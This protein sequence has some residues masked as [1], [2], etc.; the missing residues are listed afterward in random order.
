MMRGVGLSLPNR[1]VLFGATTV[2]EMLELTERADASGFF[3][4]VWVGDGLVAK[5]RLEAVTSLAAIAARTKTVQLGVCCLATFALRQPVLFALQWA[6]LDFLSGGRTLLAVCLGAPTARSGGDFLGELQAMGI[7]RRERVAR[8]EENIEILRK[9]WAG[10]AAHEGRF[11]S[12]PEIDLLP[13]PVQDPCPIWIASNPS[14]EV[15]SP[16]RYQNAIDRV[17]RLADGWQSTVVAPDDFGKRWRE[18][19]ASAQRFGRDPS[20]MTS[21]VHLMINVAD[22]VEQGR[23]EGKRFLDKYYSMDV[24]DATMDKWGAYGPPEVVLERINEYMDEGLDIPIVRFASYDQT[25][26]M[27]R[28]SQMLLPELSRRCQDGA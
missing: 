26:Q 2:S 6:S 5:A 25:E 10:P 28:A 22:T 27:D 13:R 8:F 3:G 21:S 9:L 17:G 20:T 4:S 18:V 23:A 15:L 19:K 12:F 1:G 7:E 11:V 16:E 24:D 14:P